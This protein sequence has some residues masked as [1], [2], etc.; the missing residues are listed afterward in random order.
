MTPT[1]PSEKPA[2]PARLTTERQERLI[3]QLRLG[4]TVRGATAMAGLSKTSFY[5]WMKR[6]RQELDRLEADPDAAPLRA[7]AKYVRFWLAV[8]Q[9]MAEAEARHLRVI[10][11]AAQGGAEWVETIVVLGKDGKPIRKTAKKKV[12]GPQWLASRWWLERCAPD[13]GGRRFEVVGLENERIKF[14]QA[15]DLT[16]LDNEELALLERLLEKCALVLDVAAGGKSGT[17]EE[18]RA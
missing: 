3:E 15:L 4:H 12:A 18:G 6:G 16:K 2:K 5:F 17:Q 14:A 11:A 8:D 13:F 10:D 9:A 7:E 1:S